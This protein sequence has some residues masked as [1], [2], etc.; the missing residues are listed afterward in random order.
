MDALFYLPLTSSKSS[1]WIALV[2]SSGGMVGYA[3]VDGFD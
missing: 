3:E 2:D 1:D